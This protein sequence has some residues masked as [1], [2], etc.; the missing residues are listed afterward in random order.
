M[1]ILDNPRCSF[2]GRF[3]E[4]IL[5]LFWECSIVSS[6][7]LDVEQ[8]I[9][10]RQFMFSKKDILFGYN[11]SLNHPYNFFIFHLKYFIFNVKL[12][13]QSLVAA[14]FL[15]KFK[16]ALKVEKELKSK[17]AKSHISYNQLKDAFKCCNLLF[18]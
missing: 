11:M 4:T 15:H 14:N 12:S 1:K 7:I 13:T 10:A 8:T 2:C 16:F 18:R 5:H 6:F 3:D 9:F 17:T